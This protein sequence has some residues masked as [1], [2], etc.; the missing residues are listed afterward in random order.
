VL[1]NSC[2]KAGCHDDISSE[3]GN[4]LVT[5]YES[6]LKA[7]KPGNAKGSRLYK[8]ITNINSDNLMP[9][10]QPLSEQQRMLIEIWIEQGALNEKCSSGSSSSSSGGP[11]SDSVCFKQIILPMIVSNCA[12]PACHDGLSSGE[13]D[14]LSALNS[15]TT[16]ISGGVVPYYPEESSVY[17][18]VISEGEDVMPPLPK[19][20]LTPA[21]KALLYKWI[22]DGALNSD[23]PNANCDTTGT[24]GYTAQ[25]KPIM[26]NNCVSCHNDASTSGGVNLDGYSNVQLYGSTLRSG[27]PILLGVIR[28]MSGF[29][30]MPP[31]SKLDDCTIRKIELWIGQ[32]MPN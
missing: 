2:G 21:Q 5:S 11:T 20:P 22:A 6:I 14:E 19:T 15:H 25:I 27:T 18:T 17:L 16:I 28:Q 29:K 32:G 12:M 10:D 1:K 26:D 24:I 4:F 9:P 23:C 31:G 8:V 7:V 13:E 3:G 30:I